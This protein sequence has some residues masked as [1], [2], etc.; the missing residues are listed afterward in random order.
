MKVPFRAFVHRILTYPL[1]LPIVM[2]Y[3][4]SSANRR[5]ILDVFYMVRGFPHGYVKDKNRVAFY[6][7]FRI[8]FPFDEDPSFDDVWLRNV[9]YTYVP[10][11]HHI[12]IDVGAHMGF[13]I[14][15]TVRDVKKVIAVEP[16]PTN[17]EFLGLNI[18]LNKLED[19]VLL[20]NLAF[21][22]KDGEIYL[23]RSGYGF[24]RS[25]ITTSKADCL[26]EMRTVDSFMEE[27]RL[28]QVDL[29]KID[30][31]G[32]ELEILKGARKT[33]QKHRPDLLIAA[34]HF[35]KEHLIL[36]DYLKKYG[37]RILSYR[38]PLFLSSS[39]EIYLY[40]KGKPQP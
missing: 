16:D 10:Q 5:K 22:E 17:F 1:L 19:K 28:R 8:I 29:I 27:I 2:L 7:N 31:E 6:D 36:A 3:E 4:L 9:Y 37:Y 21:G 32:S 20:Y 13:F 30:T 38:V 18:R 25:K 26:V 39:E 15:K 12:V 14:L 35:N 23:D 33:L 11:Q 34:Y 24:G 40:A